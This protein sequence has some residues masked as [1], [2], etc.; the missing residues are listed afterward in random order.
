MQYSNCNN[1]KWNIFSF[2]MNILAHTYIHTRTTSKIQPRKGYLSPIDLF[3]FNN[4]HCIKEALNCFFIYCCISIYLNILSD[5]LIYT[6]V[7][8]WLK[9]DSVMSNFLFYFNLCFPYSPCSTGN[10][11]WSDS[12]SNSFSLCFKSCI[13]IWCNL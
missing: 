2:E 10:S 13:D 12:S 9:S 1:R 8:P 11:T 5:N 7:I 6:T 3:L 4:C